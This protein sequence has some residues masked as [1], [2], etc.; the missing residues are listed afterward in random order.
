M[1]IHILCSAESNVDLLK[2]DV[3]I[4]DKGEDDCKKFSGFYDLVVLSNLFR[5]KRTLECSR[6][7]YNEVVI[8]SLCREKK[9]SICDFVEGEEMKMESDI[10][11]EDRVYNFLRELEKYHNDYERILVVTHPVF[12]WYIKRFISGNRYFMWLVSKEFETFVSKLTFL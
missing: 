1:S 12:I 7:N 5:S 4:T 8:S 10:E 11:I 2:R 9:D 6:I 3:S